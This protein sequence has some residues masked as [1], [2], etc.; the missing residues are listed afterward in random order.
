MKPF[1]LLPFWF[2]ALAVGLSL[3]AAPTPPKGATLLT[4]RASS[5]STNSAAPAITN[6]ILSW[7]TW[8]NPLQVQHATNLAGPWTPLT[9]IYPVWP[10]NL[11]VPVT[12]PREFFRFSILPPP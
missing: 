1:F 6:I 3:A 12:E 2:A 5:V 4:R 10:T 8:T 9:N 7:A 11:V